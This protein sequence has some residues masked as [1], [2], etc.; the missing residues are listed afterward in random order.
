MPQIEISPS[1]FEKLQR[2]AQPLVDTTE[3]VIAR[4]ADDALARLRPGSASSNTGDGSFNGIDLDPFDPGSLSF[5]RVRRAT[6]NG[7]Q[8][9]R[10]KWNKLLREMHVLAFK[11]LGSFDQL[12]GLSTARL[13]QGKWEE[14]GFS[15]LPEVDFS[16]QGL[17]S[18]LSWDGSIRLARHLEV[19]IVVEFEWYEKPRATHPGEK[20]RL[21]WIPPQK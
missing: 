5:T 2:L 12:Q 16:I 1:T 20:G 15:Y 3:T 9:D 19:P 17:D 13:R 18:N 11:R 21:R 8:I 6:I 10:P 14:E 7:V 4:L